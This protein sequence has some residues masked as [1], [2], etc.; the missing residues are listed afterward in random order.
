VNQLTI[1]Y[2]LTA[3]YGL[4]FRNTIAYTIHNLGEERMDPTKLHRSVSPGRLAEE[5][6]KLLRPGLIARYSHNLQRQTTV[7]RMPAWHNGEK[8]PVVPVEKH[9]YKATFEGFVQ[10]PLKGEYQ[11]AVRAN[12][13]SWKLFLNG[14]QVI[15]GKAAPANI[16][17][18]GGYNAMRLEFDG[19]P[20]D[21]MFSLR[22]MWAKPGEALASIPPSAL[23][24]RS[25]DA[26]L[27]QSQQ[28]ERGRRLFETRNC[29]RCHALE[30]G[31]KPDEP[32]APN[33]I[34][35][36]KRFRRAWLA[37]WILK[38]GD[39]RNEPVMPCLLDPAQGAD[40]QTAANLAAFLSGV[41]REETPEP[42]DDEAFARGRDL[43]E[44]LGCIVCHR[45]TPP[46]EKDEFN[47]VSLHFVNAKFTPE[48]LKRY[49]RTPQAHFPLTRMPDLKLQEEELQGL[50]AYLRKAAT[51]V[52]EPLPEL[53][54][55]DA[56]AG[57]IAQHKLRCNAC[58]TPADSAEL[59]PRTAIRR[60][61][62]GCLAA[63]P[64]GTVPR[65]VWQAGEREALLAYLDKRAELWPSSDPAV[66]SQQL[67]RELRCNACH[68]RDG[69]GG[70][71]LAIL[72][73][74]SEHGLTPEVLPDL[75][76]AGEKLQAKWVKRQI[77]GELPQSVRPWLKARMPAFPA[78]AESLAAG[79]AA[80][81]GVSGDGGA[82]R[83][84]PD[85]A[86]I[87]EQL[88]LKEALDC[89]QC[90]AIGKLEPLGDD[91]TK[92]APGINFD[93]IA[94]RLQYD[95]YRR[96]VLDPPRWDVTSRMPQ[97]APDGKTTKVTG[98]YD[99]DAEKQFEAIWNYIQSVKAE[100]K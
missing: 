68:R 35:T 75:T 23:F 63:A 46:A 66:V 61:E 3:A 97:L 15:D 39:L 44:D 48:N 49:L 78:Y 11:F 41:E 20:I 69:D 96:F 37:A 18:H 80:E 92:L 82:N 4:E 53:A 52:I 58:H 28:L 51:G 79:F 34:E 6:E 31:T 14:E 98:F 25:D 36:G 27:V 12:G 57:A 8:F 85:L 86:K 93:Q 2:A 70:P 24:H 62:E 9:P 21:G 72:G 89:R 33:R 17:L 26:G 30:A 29:Q 99:G 73:E 67:F 56:K 83:A 90:H 5:V 74:E 42:P 71:R 88:T 91:K 84:N 55:A 38:P 16:V 10:V 50:T 40:R 22:L 77:A 54:Q 60:K 43:Y 59:P 7:V 64:A 94:H 100:K 1:G 47:R 76:W 19:G 81:H 95:Y 32:H 87:G 65:F 45:L 13:E